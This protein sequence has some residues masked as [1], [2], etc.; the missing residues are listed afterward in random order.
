MLLKLKHYSVTITF[1]LFDSV[2]SLLISTSFKQKLKNA[3]SNCD[4]FI[5]DWT[6]RNLQTH[7]QLAFAEYL[8]CNCREIAIV[9]LVNRESLCRGQMKKAS[10]R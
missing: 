1:D 7:G 9:R 6:I 10:S 5:K 4:D 8:S 2:V 3:R